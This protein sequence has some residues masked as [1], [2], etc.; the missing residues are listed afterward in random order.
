MTIARQSPLSLSSSN[1]KVGDMV[2]IS[3]TLSVLGMALLSFLIPFYRRPFSSLPNP[4]ALD[5]DVQGKLRRAVA[6]KRGQWDV[7]AALAKKY[8]EYAV[9]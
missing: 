9:H 5:D 8:G 2:A 7:F 4:V 3:V 6:E 1:S